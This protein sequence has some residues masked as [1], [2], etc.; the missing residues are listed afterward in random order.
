[1]SFF[2]IT[3]AFLFR[4]Y[5]LIFL[6]ACGVLTT[7]ESSK[8]DTAVKPQDFQF[9]IDTVSS[10]PQADCQPAS[11][12][13]VN[14]NSTA[15][16][17]SEDLQ[18]NLDG[19]GSFSFHANAN[20]AD[21]GLNSILIP[22]TEGAVLFYI[23]ALHASNGVI[24]VS[25]SSPIASIF[26]P[27]KITQVSA[28]ALQ[29][30]FTGKQSI[31]IGS[32]EPYII[33]LQNMDGLSV[34]AS[35]ELTV[36]LSGNSFGALYSN[37]SCTGSTISSIKIPA[38]SSFGVF[39]YK[40]AAVEKVI[41]RADSDTE[42]SSSYKM[43]DIISS[44]SNL[45]ANGEAGPTYVPIQLLVSGPSQ[46][47]T[48]SCGG[49]YSVA[50]A[51]SNGAVVP[52][53][54]TEVVT[55]TNGAGNGLFFSDSA[56]A[57][58]ITALTFQ[59]GQ[60]VKNFYFK[61]TQAESV[62]LQAYSDNLIYGS[63]AVQVQSSG[64]LNLT[65]NSSAGS[66]WQ[67][68]IY[69]EKGTISDRTIILQNVGL[70]QANAVNLF[71]PS[72]S[73]SFS[74]RGGS[75]PGLGGTCSNGSVL[76][77]NQQ[78]SIVVRFQPTS[79]TSFTDNL[80][81]RYTVGTNN[82]E[83][84]LPLSGQANSSLN[85]L[86]VAAGSHHTCVTLTDMSTKCFGLNGK[87]Q[88]G[89]GNTTNYGVS[90]KDIETLSWTPYG[91]FATQIVGGAEHTC[92]LMA[93]GKVICWGDN[94]YGQLGRSDNNETVGGTNTDLATET[95]TYV[96]LGTGKTATKIAAGAYHTC[97]LLQDGNVKCWGRNNYGQL[98]QEDNV[99]RGTSAAT[100][101]DNLLNI[102][103]GV[104]Q[105]V[106]DL[107]SGAN[108]NCAVLQGGQLKCWGRNIF[109]QL[110]IGSTAD[111]GDNTG[112]MG[113]GLAPVSAHSGATVLSVGAGVDHTCA[114]ITIPTSAD[115]VVKCWGRNDY[116]QLGIGDALQRGTS[117]SQMGDALPIVQL[118]LSGVPKKLAL[119]RVHSCVLLA[120]GSVKCWGSNQ[121]GQ[122]GLSAS[123]SSHRGDGA[124]EMGNNL[125]TLVL[126]NSVLA[127]DISS[128]EDHSCVIIDINKI[129]CWGRND[130][131]Q[132]GHNHSASNIAS[133]GQNA[134]TMASLPDSW[135]NNYS[136]YEGLALD[137]NYSCGV[138][139]S[140]NEVICW[141]H[142]AQSSL[143]YPT[144]YHDFSAK[145]GVKQLEAGNGF[146]CVLAKND[147]NVYCWGNDA[148][149]TARPGQTTFTY[150]VPNLSSP[151]LSGYKQIAAGENFLCGITSDDA[152]KCF[153]WNIAGILGETGPGTYV[154]PAS[155]VSLAIP[156][157]TPSSIYAGAGHACV[158]N[159]SGALS[160]W[161]ANNFGQVGD[162][163]TT[164]K[165]APTTIAIGGAALAVS[166]G[167]HH[168]C[169]V[170]TGGAVQCW[171]DNQYGQVGND[172]VTTSFTTPQTI[173]LGGA[174]NAKTLSL[175]EDSS[176][177]VM[178][179]DKFRCWGRNS[180]GELA[181]GSTTNARLPQPTLLGEDFRIFIA[182]GAKRGQHR[183]A[184][185]WENAR[186]VPFQLK[187][188]GDNSAGQLGYAD[189]NDR[190]QNLATLRRAL[191]PVP[192][193]VVTPMSAFNSVPENI[194]R[195]SIF[196]L[197]SSNAQQ[198]SFYPTGAI[199]RIKLWGG[200]GGGGSGGT[201]AGANGG[202]GGHV[203]FDVPIGQVT[204]AIS[205]YVGGKGSHG[206]EYSTTYT[207]GGGGG[208]SAVFIGTTL[209]A[210]AGGGGGGGG[211]GSNSNY[212][213]SGYGGGGAGSSG[214]AGSC[215]AGGAGAY[216]GA[217]ASATANGASQQNIWSNWYSNAGTGGPGN[218][219]GGDGGQTVSG[220]A[221]VGTGGIGYG[222]GGRATRDTSYGYGGAGGGGA[223]YY[224]GAG[225]GYFSQSW[226]GWNGCGGGGGGGSNYVNVSATLVTN[227]TSS[228]SATAPGTSDADYGG[229]TA[230]GGTGT[231]SSCGSGAAGDGRVVI[232]FY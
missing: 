99:H 179:D 136:Y 122:L 157:G 8:L 27:L 107:A 182:K 228:L 86:A 33:N 1:V 72:I 173:A 74:F 106:V 175:G 5:L 108:H 58:Q 24:G 217:G 198:I 40:N 203:I 34:K 135:G 32:C 36:N 75:F 47:L 46:V 196:T 70:T 21:V 142:Q 61:D 19:K 208:S 118:G 42:V 226:P 158:I 162:N 137:K 82:M 163:T 183:C 45:G 148:W 113:T 97:A 129:R 60:S 93:D 204:A 199:A 178:T 102:S 39:Y 91:H 79:E 216:S 12:S 117:P 140:Q 141:G 223:G 10:M 127:T 194:G 139:R 88:L 207:G 31:M 98:G 111:M 96:N 154:G 138:S 167:R 52:V 59:S 6:S 23:K 44:N 165:T 115:P 174:G 11:L 103:F 54:N 172:S 87:G 131:G 232:Q 68:F 206:C 146:I 14:G 166:L 215:S 105:T 92:A 65:M 205:I 73:N 214:A 119:G 225:G 76:L 80:K 50:S 152:V 200:G 169:A 180:K 30:S 144:K 25:S 210:V 229:A 85:P 41:L 195:S 231:T 147:N 101:G 202:H 63:F 176:C 130:Y 164:A 2:R 159:D 121:Y 213:G 7:S 95:Y 43:V 13:V 114:I 9:K 151:H 170:I 133:W 94:S 100:M 89:V 51:D 132:L 181:I 192:Q 193:N 16:K 177:A 211:G 90:N 197:A 77:P 71:T 48:G 112:E 84:N 126:G 184:I 18:V 104:G 156:S 69:R 125:P 201:Y 53:Q 116:G 128:G 222:S 83:A 120:T 35:S 209:Y 20:C 55:L 155:A 171:G 62:S 190:G 150:T 4:F 149:H 66:I 230:A 67:N 22:K 110:G 145:G 29:V 153:G 28:M 218:A 49:Q 186:Q 64:R 212:C 57:N 38:L 124:D 220:T 134:N 161:G 160:C 109:G 3:G 37:S 185:G 15:I 221:P 17:Y 78:C 168:S 26:Y 123:T 189:T 219:R 191:L 227:N 81:I 224:A 187:C 56:C 188:W 143:K